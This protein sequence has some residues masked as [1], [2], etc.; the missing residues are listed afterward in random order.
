VLGASSLFTRATRDVF[1]RVTNYRQSHGL[2]ARYSPVAPLVLLAEGDWVY[3]SLTWN[4]HRGGFA[5]FLQADWEP[6]Q[7][8]HFMLTGEAKNDGN[9]DEPPSFAGWFS[10]AWFFGRHIDF[11]IDDIYQ[12]LGSK[13]GDT[14][15][16]TLLFQMHVFL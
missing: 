14:D 13:R 5:M 3:Q 4:G 16:F 15:V 11:R 6:S 7:G 8:F 9:K 12:R 10:M 2:F 1:Y